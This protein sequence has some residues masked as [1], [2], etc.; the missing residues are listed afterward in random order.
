MDAKDR[1]AF[2]NSIGTEAPRPE[3]AKNAAE[4]TSD[5]EQSPVFAEGLPDWNLE[6]PQIAVRRRRSL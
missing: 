1:A 5:V 6:P 4:A 2:I 3:N